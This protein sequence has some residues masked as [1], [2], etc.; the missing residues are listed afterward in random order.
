[1]SKLWTLRHG[2]RLY[3]WQKRAIAAFPK[4]GRGVAKVA[5]GAGKTLFAIA[6]AVKLQKMVGSDFKI[7]IVVPSKVLQVQWMHEVLHWMNAS[8]SDVGLIGNGHVSDVFGKSI[9]IA[10]VNTAIKNL[11]DLNA[12]C[13][14]SK[15][16]F[17]VLDE[18]HRYL[19]GCHSKI[20]G[21]H[22]SFRLGMS[23]T[24]NPVSYW[25][26]EVVDRNQRIGDLFF[27]M[28][29]Q[30]AVK[31]KCVSEFE[32]V[33]VGFELSS[34]GELN[35]ADV[36]SK[37]VKC[38]QLQSREI[39]RHVGERWELLFADREREKCAL[40]V[41]IDLLKCRPRSRILVFNE[42]IASIDAFV[43]KLEE[44]GISALAVHSKQSDADNMKHIEKF[45]SGDVRV[46][47]AGRSLVEGF[48]VPVADVGLVISSTTSP[49]RTIQTIGRLLR[50]K[51]GHHVAVIYRLFAE[52]TVENKV[53]DKV[54]FKND[55]GLTR[56][57]YCRFVHG[58]DGI[59]HIVECGR[60]K[61]AVCHFESVGKSL[62][63]GTVVK[64]RPTGFYFSWL[65]EGEFVVTRDDEHYLI[66]NRDEMRSMFCDNSL[67]RGTWYLCTA[68]GHVFSHLPNGNGKDDCWLCCGVVPSGMVMRAEPD[69]R[70]EP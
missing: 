10:V 47:V 9:I 42:R 45:K 64:R 46:L 29:Y 23:A 54:D 58:D 4:S 68:T 50:K 53:F 32:L 1:M 22:C 35:Y 36:T 16:T 2:V 70:G 57:R 56:N 33:H 65:P 3:D 25:P 34:R 62:S 13:E 44:V 8:S 61:L 48:D 19:G 27:E 52:N 26:L 7:L 28:N 69:K 67:K 15:G 20:N 38:R 60:D 43:C 59:D 31:E 37:I 55:I 63:R 12:M 14:V 18:C 24:P 41:L 51:D 6:L 5:T 39:L 30:D 17:L 21:L 49:V 11:D 40:Y 66:L